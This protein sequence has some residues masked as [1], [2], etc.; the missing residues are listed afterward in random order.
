MEKVTNISPKA[1]HKPINKVKRTLLLLGGLFL[2]VEAYY[3]TAFI[4]TYPMVSGLTLL[5]DHSD[6]G[7]LLSSVGLSYSVFVSVYFLFR[8][9]LKH[10]LKVAFFASLISGF[11]IYNGVEKAVDR[12]VNSASEETILCG[13]LGN[14]A[15]K[16]FLMG[17]GE[18]VPFWNS[19]SNFTKFE[20]IQLG[21][22][23]LPAALCTNKQVLSE[24]FATNKLRS[25]FKGM[26][27]TAVD[28][29][30]N[31][32]IR[33]I[34]NKFQPKINKLKLNLKSIRDGHIRV[35]NQS[36]DYRFQ[37]ALKRYH[38]ALSKGGVRWKAMQA[39]EQLAS[40][41]YN[42]KKKTPSASYFYD[43]I[44]RAELT[45]KQNELIKGQISPNR[46]ILKEFKKHIEVEK[47]RTIATLVSAWSKGKTVI[48][49]HATRAMKQSV[50]A[51]I[52]PLILISFSG[53]SILLAIASLCSL[54]IPEPKQSFS[55]KAREIST[56]ALYKTSKL[57]LSPLLII[58]AIVLFI[59]ITQTQEFMLKDIEA[60]NKKV[61]LN[62]L[63]KTQFFVYPKLMG[64][65][66][67]LNIRPSLD[68]TPSILKEEKQLID[69]YSK[70]FDQSFIE[71]KYTTPSL[72]SVVF[73]SIAMDSYGKL[74][75]R[76]IED[77]NTITSFYSTRCKYD[78]FDTDALSCIKMNYMKALAMTDE[79]SSFNKT[80]LTI[81]A[82][83]KSLATMVI[84]KMDNY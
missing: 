1:P 72:Q 65:F 11:S 27:E 2:L 78:N 39:L 26:V 13:V 70:T 16:N 9:S 17:E 61:L 52:S 71:K 6:F 21:L 48:G 75:E 49:T 47:S 84:E 55:S 42:K 58:P 45:D 7:R 33:M 35:V 12:F 81:V 36:S 20:D 64:A 80:W 8:K 68:M 37:K 28:S 79:G 3:I 50:K 77:L 25:D 59:P 74:K 51:V 73:S 22:V 62:S 29:R 53:L 41:V 76:H 38:R 82:K 4:N 10:P 56:K 57:I 15:K 34:N 54:L 31:N 5:K 63:L 69:H 24:S 23:L 67:A 66:Q 30:A 46:D 32:E 14:Y 60:G 44:I 83:A 18:A 19:E 43:K 40:D